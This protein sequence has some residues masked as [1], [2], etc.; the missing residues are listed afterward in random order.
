MMEFDDLGI[1]LFML[2]FVV[3]P[4]I[5][6]LI[7]QRF[8]SAKAALISIAAVLVLSIASLAIAGLGPHAFILIPLLPMWAGCIISMI[9]S[10]IVLIRAR[11]K[12]KA[13]EASETL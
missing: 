11:M 10:T 4:I 13:A 3:A 12:S 1:T 6:G 7:I 9:I 5:L 2:G 8:M